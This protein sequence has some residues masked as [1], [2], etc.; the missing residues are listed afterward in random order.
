MREKIFAMLLAAEDYLSGEEISQ[1]LGISRAAV[2][3][4]IKALQNEGYQIECLRK[5][6]YRLVANG[7]HQEEIAP[8]LTTKW[9]G[10]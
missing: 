1:T 5:K 9:L 6:G 3:K 7:L 4:H 10:R 8:F 2:W